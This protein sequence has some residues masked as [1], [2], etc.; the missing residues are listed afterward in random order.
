MPRSQTFEWMSTRAPG[1]PAGA[2]AFDRQF[3][4]FVRERAR[5]LFNL[6]FPVETA[7]GRIDAAL[8]WE[9][10]TT[11]WPRKAPAFLEKVPAWVREVY[12]QM[13]PGKA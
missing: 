8:R 12:A 5:L 2:A 9:L 6:R 3:E 1:T 13:T 4:K 7:I 10:D 11:V